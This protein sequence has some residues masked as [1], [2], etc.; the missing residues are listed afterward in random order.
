MKRIFLFFL[1]AAL[2]LNCAGCGG[3]PPAETPSAVSPPAQSAPP[4]GD[5]P[6]VQSIPA[7]GVEGYAD[8]EIAV[9]LPAEYA[10]LRKPDD[11]GSDEQYTAAVFKL[12]FSG[13][14]QLWIEQQKSADI[15]LLSLLSDVPFYP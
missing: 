1:C 13:E 12:Q 14:A 15:Y 6:P 2:A 5:T 4:A 10:G 8:G 9:F 7:P 11:T 3:T